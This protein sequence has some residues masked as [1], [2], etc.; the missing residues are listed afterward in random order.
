MINTKHVSGRRELHYDTLDELLADAEQLARGEVRMLGNWS[1]G[2][3][4]RHFTIVYENSIDG[5]PFLLPGIARFL[6]RITMKRRLLEQPLERGG[7]D[8]DVEDLLL[9]NIA[10]VDHERRAEVDPGAPVATGKDPVE[11]PAHLAGSGDAH[12]QPGLGSGCGDG[13]RPGP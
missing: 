5:S 2:Q 12:Q 3:V 11:R 8:H 6:I 10:H 7:R 4:F 1:L 9:G 13:G